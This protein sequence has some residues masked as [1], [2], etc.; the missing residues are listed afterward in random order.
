MTI[1]EENELD[2]K[3]L[4]IVLWH[5]S[6]RLITKIGRILEDARAAFERTSTP[7]HAEWYDRNLAMVTRF[8]KLTGKKFT[9][10]TNWC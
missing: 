2:S 5:S 10:R 7:G 1:S 8:E 9:D 6:S 4:R 3:L